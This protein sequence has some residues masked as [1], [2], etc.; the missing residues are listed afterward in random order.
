MP[1]AINSETK[2]TTN[3]LSDINSGVADD[4]A[5]SQTSWRVMAVLRKTKN[6]NIERDLLIFVGESVSCV[7]VGGFT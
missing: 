4:D 6:R 1:D 5:N 3:W 2:T 7:C